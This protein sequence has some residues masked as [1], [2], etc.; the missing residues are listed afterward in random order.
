MAET[1]SSIGGHEICDGPRPFLWERI[2][3]DLTSCIPNLFQTLNSY[4]EFNLWE[5]PLPFW[6][7]S[8]QSQGY[9]IGNRYDDEM[10]YPIFIEIVQIL[11]QK[12]GNVSE[13]IIGGGLVLH[14]SRY[15]SALQFMR[16]EYTIST[17]E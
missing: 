14:P 7:I 9:S 13:Y 11:N 4:K 3:E 10:L 6:I 12:K 15:I 16:F 8:H 2:C 1:G 17:G 5:K